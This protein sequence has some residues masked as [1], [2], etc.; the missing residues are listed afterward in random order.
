[1]R[2][3]DFESPNSMPTLR[4]TFA[5]SS[6]MNQLILRIDKQFDAVHEKTMVHSRARSPQFVTNGR[7][8]F[9]EDG[10]TFHDG[11]FYSLSTQ[12]SQIHSG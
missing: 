3:A 5:M 1:M 6:P 8:N 11:V 2:G 12:A 7:L 9:S 4:C 10:N